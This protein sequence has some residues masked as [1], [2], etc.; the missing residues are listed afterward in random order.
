MAVDT[1]AHIAVLGAG[2]IGLEAALYARFLG[3][4][5]TLY[6]QGHIAEQVL[7]WGHAR[8][9]TPWHMNV[10]PLGLAALHTQLPDWQPPADDALLSGRQ[11]AEAYLLPLAASDLLAD[12]LQ[13][14]T[15]VLAIARRGLLRGDADGDERGE[16]ELLV[17]MRDTSGA[18]RIDK[19]D[20]VIDATGV[21]GQPNHLG[22]GGLPA[23]GE[24]QLVEAIEYGLPDIAGEQRERYAGRRVLVVGGGHSAATNVLALAALEPPPRIF[25]VTRRLPDEATPGPLR[26]VSKDPLSE[27]DRVARAA[28]ALAGNALAGNALAGSAHPA[29]THLP[30][31]WVKRI[32]FSAGT[33]RVQLVGEQKQEI[34]V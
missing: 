26:L 23:L 34:E 32:D 17:L 33:Y 30:G 28:N 22:R 12:S 20:V 6:E 5:V 9:F 24:R 18:E 16:R 2:P 19:V 21:C 29:V 13:P 4:D 10:S 11:W 15:Q 27:R 14:E 3:Y 7:R 1:P 31:C 8:M 25:W